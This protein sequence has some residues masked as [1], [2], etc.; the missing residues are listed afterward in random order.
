MPTVISKEYLFLL[1]MAGIIKLLIFL[2]FLKV[3][4]QFRS[5]AF[6]VGSGSC[7]P[8]RILDFENKTN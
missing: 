2:W 5:R 8:I 4:I 1:S 6:L 7:Y 3:C